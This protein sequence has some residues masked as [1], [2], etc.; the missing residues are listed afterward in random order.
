MRSSTMRLTRPRL[1]LRRCSMQEAPP[2]SVS[3]TRKSR[4]PQAVDTATSY[5]SSIEAK[6]PRRPM[7]PDLA[8]GLPG[9]AC[10]RRAPT[11]PP[12]LRFA[13][14]SCAC[15]SAAF[16]SSAA[17]TAADMA[18]FSPL[19]WPFNFSSSLSQ[20][21]PR[22]SSVS[23]FAPD[24]LSSFA[25]ASRSLLSRSKSFSTLACSSFA[26]SAACVMSLISVSVVP[27][28]ASTSD[29]CCFTG[30][31]AACFSS[32]PPR[33][34]SVSA[35]AASSN[36]SMRCSSLTFFAAALPTAA[37]SE[38]TAASHF[39]AFN[40]AAPALSSSSFTV[41]A[42]FFSVDLLN[43]I[44]SRSL[45]S[46]RSNAVN[47]FLVASSSFTIKS[48]SDARL[49]AL[50]SSSDSSAAFSL[51][52]AA[53]YALRSLSSSCLPLNP[54]EMALASAP[55]FWYSTLCFCRTSLPFRTLASA[56]TFAPSRLSRSVSVTFALASFSARSSL[57]P[58][59]SFSEQVMPSKCRLLP[60]MSSKN[61]SSPS[62]CS[63]FALGG[64]MAICSTS[65]CRIRKRLLSR[66]MPR[67]LRSAPTSP[68]F[69]ALPSS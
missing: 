9:F 55:F 23:L 26:A 16:P 27:M 31:I 50:P 39:S 32:N 48:C 20:A 51:S 53:S 35:L 14:D 33:S 12:P 62:S 60:M 30:A 3:T 68:K 64:I 67:F 29:T 21:F 40:F 15:A 61:S 1:C 25:F 69:D 59:S 17:I 13:A 6:S 28:D 5:F 52:F 49:E 11:T 22:A 63:V 7:S 54:A 2:L 58:S 56:S 65:P 24:W 57:S 19:S 66:S 10:A 8:R 18:C 36:A 34:A 38:G 37:S 42:S 47:C 41:Q 45:M 4:Y 46:C 43:L 44:S